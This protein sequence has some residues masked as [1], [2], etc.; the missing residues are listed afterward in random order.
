MPELR[1]GSP[2]MHQRFTLLGMPFNQMGMED[3]KRE[4]MTL[5]SGPFKY[6]TTPN[7]DHVV[8]ANADRAVA[9]VYLKA[10][11]CLCDSRLLALLVRLVGMGRLQVVTGSDLT[12]ELFESGLLASMRVCVIG[13]SERTIEALKGRFHLSNLIHHNPPHGFISD[14]TL[15]QKAVKSIIEARAEII[16]LAVGS[17]QQELLAAHIER[18]GKATGVALCVGASLLFLSGEE[19]R[20]PNWIQLLCFEWLFRLMTNPKRL[21]RRYA[22]GAPKIIRLLLEERFR[23]WRGVAS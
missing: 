16:F 14:A 5:A 7:I 15:V 1:A 21:W 4:V 23:R 3:A 22:L 12:R 6:V 2:D 8:R 13:G 17:P 19:K 10:R 11:L 20:A 9:S 18:S